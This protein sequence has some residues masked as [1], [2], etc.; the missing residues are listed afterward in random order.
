MSEKL[1]PCKRCKK[2]WGNEGLPRLYERT[3]SDTGGYYPA[4]IR[5]EQCRHC[6]AAGDSSEEAISNWNFEMRKDEGSTETA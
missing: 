2:K 4:H 3:E 6:G 1:R 5:C